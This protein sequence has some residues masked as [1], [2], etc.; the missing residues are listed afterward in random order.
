MKQLIAISRHISFEV[1]EA[2][3]HVTNDRNP[4]HLDPVY[5]ANTPMGGIIAHGMLPMNLLWQMLVRSFGPESVKDTQLEVRFTRPVRVDDTVTAGGAP[6]AHTDPDR[7]CFNVW[8]RNQHDKPVIEG[9][10]TIGARYA[11]Q[12]D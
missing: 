7:L 12:E 5:A 3:A 2:Y 4:L 11:R 6:T 10:L 1:I 9:T 8:V